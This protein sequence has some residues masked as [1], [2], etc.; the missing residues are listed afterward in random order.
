M[1]ELLPC[2][3][4]GSND[5]LKLSDCGYSSFNVGHINCDCGVYQ[6]TLNAYSCY[7]E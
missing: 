1:K 4:Y 7:P 2:P 3:K 5:K 6:L